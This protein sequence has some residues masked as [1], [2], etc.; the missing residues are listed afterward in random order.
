MTARLAGRHVVVTRSADQAGRL[1]DLLTAEGATVVTVPT[2][3]IADPDDG[4]VALRAALRELWDWVVVT[5]RNGAERT[6]A[7]AGGRAAALALPW[8]AVGPGTAEA[9]AERGVTAAF[10]PPHF[11]AESLVEAFPAPPC[12]RP[13]RVLVAQA[14][15]ARKV[16]ALG[17]RDKGWDVS[18]V[19]AYRTIP[20]R[21]DPVVLAQART[22]DAIAFTSGSTVTSY[23]AACGPDGLP[24]VAVVIGP[25]TADVARAGGIEVSAVADPHSLEGLVTAL[26][27]ALGG[28][29]AA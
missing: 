22:A 27:D 10:V 24:P 14:E 2:I 18:T 23:L 13:G 21:P 12:D 5:S 20:V 7:A 28:P 8:A 6:F 26:A 16:V 3:A 9:L 4:G 17:L 1:A 29:P 11:I 19:V 25:I 15:A